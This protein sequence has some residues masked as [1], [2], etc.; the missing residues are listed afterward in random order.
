MPTFIPKNANIV[1]HWWTL[2][3]VGW[4]NEPNTC[5]Q[6]LSAY[7]SNTNSNNNTG[8]TTLLLGREYASL[9]PLIVSRSIFQPLL[10]FG[11]PRIKFSRRNLQKLGTINPAPTYLILSNFP[12]PCFSGIPSPHL[13]MP[14]EFFLP[15]S[16]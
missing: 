10:L 1:W 2:L 9:P 6:H 4:S 14:G 15:S 3:D 7:L 12:A 13:L 16:L 8:S 5:T 11:A